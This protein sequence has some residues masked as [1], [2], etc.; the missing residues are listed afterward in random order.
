M[1]AER[2]SESVRKPAIACSLQFAVGGCKLHVLARDAGC[3]TLLGAASD[4][5]DRQAALC[6]L[7]PRRRWPPWATAGSRS[8]RSPAWPNCSGSGAALALHLRCSCCQLQRARSPVGHVVHR[9]RPLRTAARHQLDNERALKLVLGTG[10][11]MYEVLRYFG[12]HFA[13]CIYRLRATQQQ[14]HL[15]K[16]DSANASM[17]AHET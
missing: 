6:C 2:R 17:H 1:E 3:D 12:V 10:T 8:S 4:L 9:R 14:P 5:G 11:C 15:Q 7:R 16:V 13:V